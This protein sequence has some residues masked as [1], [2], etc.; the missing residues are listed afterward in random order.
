MFRLEVIV[1]DKNVVGV[2]KALNGKVVGEPKW[3]EVI[4]A[5]VEQVTPETTVIK[6]DGLGTTLPVRVTNYLLKHTTGPTVK[7]T[8]VVEAIK[9]SGGQPN[10]ITYVLQ[11]MALHKAILKSNGGGHGDN[12]I[13]ALRRTNGNGQHAVGA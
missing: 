12:A 6:A 3:R 10:S 13:Y 8:Q 7:R 1:E 4:G 5:I 2:M 11:Q 9:R